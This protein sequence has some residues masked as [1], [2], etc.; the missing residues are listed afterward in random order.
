MPREARNAATTF[1]NYSA[2]SI[3]RRAAYRRA[4]KAAGDLEVLEYLRRAEA[5]MRFCRVCHEWK[6]TANFYKLP[7]IASISGV[8]K[9][10]NSNL[11]SKYPRPEGLLP[12]LWSTYCAA[13]QRL[14]ISPLVYYEQREKGLYWCAGCRGWYSAAGSG[15]ASEVIVASTS[16]SR[17]QYCAACRVEQQQ[18]KMARR[19]G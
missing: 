14:N 1:W 7:T 17:E 10:C 2:M 5:G 13:A 3:K 19:Q 8:C 11:H 6:V 15:E 9:D 16:T 4:A 12:S 18:R